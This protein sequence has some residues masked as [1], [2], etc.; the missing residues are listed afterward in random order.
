MLCGLAKKKHLVG[1]RLWGCGKLR[2][3]GVG[4]MLGGCGG[5]G[6]LGCG[7]WWCR[8]LGVWGYGSLGVWVSGGVGV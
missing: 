3:E 8:C 2:E 6:S 5:C 4:H 1:C 7:V